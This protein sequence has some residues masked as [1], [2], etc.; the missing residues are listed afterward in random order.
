MFCYRINSHNLNWQVKAEE[1]G[2]H[3]HTH[4]YNGNDSGNDCDDDDDVY[5]D[6]I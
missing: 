6:L 1:Y 3:N 2:N 4:N 5:D